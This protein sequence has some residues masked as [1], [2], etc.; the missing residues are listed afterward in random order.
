MTAFWTNTQRHLGLTICLVFRNAAAAT[1]LLATIV[2]TT[3]PAQPQDH[4]ALVGAESRLELGQQALENGELEIAQRLLREA[5]QILKID[6]G[7]RTQAQLV[8][9]RQLMWAEMRA[10]QWT[11]LETS[12]EHYYWLLDQIQE[13]TLSSQLGIIRDLRQLNLEAAGH[14]QNPAPAKHFSDAQRLN[15]QALSFIEAILGED[16]PRLVPWL[17]DGLLLQHLENRLL[18]KRGLSN[19]QYKTNGREIVSGWSLS[20]GE[21]SR[22]SYAIG[23]DLLD[24]MEAICLSK[25]SSADNRALV[26]SLAKRHAGDWALLN[27]RSDI[28]A[29]YYAQAEALWPKNQTPRATLETDVIGLQQLPRERFTLYS[30]ENIEGSKPAE[31]QWLNGFDN[32]R[33]SLLVALSTSMPSSHIPCIRN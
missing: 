32:V 5:V 28:A 17:Y 22:A 14:P 4:Y 3:A 13:S 18:D 27:R 25:S 19:Y 11:E 7:L 21:I 15:W 30:I 31:A 16:S 12:L 24:R 10:A 6:K 9:L 23:V 2:S 8:P 29:G 20:S 26:S 33:P 1:A